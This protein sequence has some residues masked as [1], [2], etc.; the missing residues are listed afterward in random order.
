MTLVNEFIQFLPVQLN[1]LPIIVNGNRL[2]L[3]PFLVNFYKKNCGHKG[4]NLKILIN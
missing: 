1:S 4:Y 3:D 2:K